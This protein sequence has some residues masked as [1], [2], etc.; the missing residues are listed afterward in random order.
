[1]Q[2]SLFLFVCMVF[3]HKSKSLSANQKN[4]EFRIGNSKFVKPMWWV[5][6][7]YYVSC[8]SHVN[9]QFWI[10]IINEPG[11]LQ[12]IPNGWFDTY[13]VKVN[14]DIFKYQE[15]VQLISQ[16]E[17]FF[18]FF[19][20]LLEFASLPCNNCKTILKCLHPLGM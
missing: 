5:G 20:G 10:L 17:R 8:P 2:V 13:E 12:T 14:I 6:Y 19:N 3:H 11:L 9:K 18:S 15:K 16:F 1:M 4:S 7:R